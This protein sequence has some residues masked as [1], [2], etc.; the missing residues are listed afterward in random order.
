MITEDGRQRWQFSLRSFLFA[1]L[2]VGPIAGVAGPIILESIT[3]WK[4][5]PRPLPP[6]PKARSAALSSETG[7]YYES[8][9]TPLR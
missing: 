5:P 9:E 2:V 7:S 6:Q 3:E 4:P 8:G 1:V